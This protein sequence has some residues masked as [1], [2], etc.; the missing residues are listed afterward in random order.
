MS[1]RK[2]HTICC[3]SPTRRTS[4]PWASPVVPAPNDEI[5]IRVAAS[6]LLW[7]PKYRHRGSCFSRWPGVA[8]WT[9]ICAPMPQQALQKRELGICLSAPWPLFWKSN[10]LQVSRCWQLLWLADLLSAPVS[11]RCVEATVPVIPPEVLDSACHHHGVDSVWHQG[12]RAWVIEQSSSQTKVLIARWIGP[13]ELE[14]KCKGFAL[15]FGILKVS[16]WV[17]N[18]L[19]HLLCVGSMKPM[20]CGPYHY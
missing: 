14:L 1:S 18:H 20:E 3:A 9:I 19:A 8:W 5:A 13:Q 2:Q 7:A 16:S 15:R 4:R 17:Q 10:K 12:L 11:I 6:L